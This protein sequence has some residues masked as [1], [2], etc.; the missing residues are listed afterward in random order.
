VTEIVTLSRRGRRVRVGITIIVGA[1]LLAGSIWGSDDD[2]PFG[3]FSMYAG[4]NGPDDAAPDTRI[5]GVDA[6][7]RT[8][9]LTESN[10]GVRRAEIEGQLAEYEAHG[11]RLAPIAAEYARL[12]PTAPPI[13]RVSVIVRLYEI[14]HSRVTGRWHDEVH[15]TWQVAR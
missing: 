8:I 5:E 12:N 9:I 3:P 2:F 10:A 4:V 14:R 1:M 13:V 6:T 7:G 15:A 11:E